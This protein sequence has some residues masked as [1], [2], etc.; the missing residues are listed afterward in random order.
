[1]PVFE[2][3]CKKCEAQYEALTKYDGTQKYKTVKCPECGSKKKELRMSSGP[4]F[5]FANP[6][7]TDRW[8]SHDYRFYHNLPNAKAERAIAAKAS[9]VGQNPYKKID[10]VSG[11]KHFGKVK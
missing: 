10:D 11:G 8:R 6:E 3:K 7:G 4:G 1:M 5:S 2:F 9:K